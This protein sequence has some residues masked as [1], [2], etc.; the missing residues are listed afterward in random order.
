MFDAVTVPLNKLKEVVKS[1][2][3]DFEDVDT[4]F[5]YLKMNGMISIKKK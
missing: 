1:L 3:L 4:K 2:N 5:E